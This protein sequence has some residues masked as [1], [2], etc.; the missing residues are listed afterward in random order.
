MGSDP[1]HAA[2][3]SKAAN[4]GANKFLIKSPGNRNAYIKQEDDDVFGV[5]LSV[6]SV[7][8]YIFLANSAQPRCQ[9]GMAFHHAFDFALTGREI[10][11]APVA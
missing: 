8:A 6:N 5:A 7:N 9:P 4:N 2:S 1:P 3:K 10:P 11:V